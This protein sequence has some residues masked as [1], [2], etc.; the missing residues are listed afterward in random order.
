[1]LLKQGGKPLAM[2]LQPRDSQT[3]GKNV[4]IKVNNFLNK[5]VTKRAERLFPRLSGSQETGVI[6][7]RKYKQTYRS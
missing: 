5:S 4:D 7:R 6:R 2:R 3:G 1:M